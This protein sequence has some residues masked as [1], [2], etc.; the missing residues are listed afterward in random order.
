[1]GTRC[2]QTPIGTYDDGRTVYSYKLEDEKGQYVSIMNIGCSLLELAV[3]DKNGELRD[4]VLG[5][6]SFEHYRKSRSVM[7]ATVGRCANRI[8]NGTFSLNGMEYRLETNEPGGMN[9]LHGGSGGFQMRYWDAAVEGDTLTFR[10]DSAGGEEGY[11]GRLTSIET[12]TFRDGRL[13]IHIQSTCDMDT[14]VNC[15][16]HAF[17]NMN[18][19]DSGSTLNHRLTINAEYYSEADQNLI[20]INTV[21]VEGTP[22]DFRTPHTIGER[23]DADF[24]QLRHSGGYDVN[25]VLSGGAPA[26]TVVG[27][28]SGIRMELYTECPDIQFFSGIGLDSPFLCHGKNG[29]TYVNYGGFCLEP[30]AVPNAINTPLAGQVILRAGESKSWNMC[31]AFSVEK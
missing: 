13:S 25:Y 4:V 22:F 26:A 21:P 20:P 9:H 7:G 6:P 18:G 23:I 3:L 17:F 11:P 15:T 14:I 30:Q 1:M 2:I 27:D 24:A 29:V 31:L 19:Q 16:N 8:A 10:Y 12:I 5:M 28:I